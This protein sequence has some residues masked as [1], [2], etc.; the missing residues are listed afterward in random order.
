MDIENIPL[1]MHVVIVQG[2]APW[3]DP[4]RERERERERPAREISGSDACSP[5]YPPAYP[6]TKHTSVGR[7]P[8]PETPADS[9]AAVTATPV[10]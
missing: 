4:Q 9:G 6:D 2:V 7:T 10:A 5:T 3:L 1:A 8:G